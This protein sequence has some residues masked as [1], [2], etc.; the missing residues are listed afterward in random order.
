MFEEQFT[1]YPSAD[2]RN[3]D[4]IDLLSVGDVKAVISKLDGRNDETVRAAKMYNPMLHDIM[5]DP[6][7][8]GKFIEGA[9][10]K[11][12]SYVKKWKLPIAYPRYINEVALVFLYGRPVKWGCESTDTDKAFEEFQKLL[13][14]THFDSKVRQ[15]KRYAGAY[16]QS[17]MLFRVYQD[18]NGK[19]D[20]QIRVLSHE[21]NDKI[22]TR[23][24]Q[25]GN[26]LS[27]AWGYT[28]LEGETPVEHFDL[29][30][31][32]YIY[33]CQRGEK[34]W[35]INVQENK[36]KKIPVIYCQQEVEWAGVEPQIEREEYI[37]SRTADTNDYFADPQL[38]IHT[39][40][41]KNMP[42][43]DDA[44]KTWLVS[45]ENASADKMAKYLTWDSAPESK[46]KEVE[47]LQNHILSKTFTPNIDFENMKTLSNVSGKAL[48]Q[49]MVL[50]NIK[51]QK[52]QEQHDELIERSAN[53]MR[54]IIGNVL[55]V[56]LAKECERMVLTH[57]FQ[58]PFGEDIAEAIDCLVKAVDGGIQSRESAVEQSPLTKNPQAELERL[59]KEQES[60]LAA[61]RDVFYQQ[62]IVEEGRSE[63]VDT[64]EAN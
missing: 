35:D 38:I 62:S 15:M 52:H 23:F 57:E 47:Q 51:A 61:Q 46:Q 27:F 29:F 26:L 56:S 21:K 4:L 54:A 18:D 48:K 34:G 24:D 31:S 39:D 33:Y 55:N 16:T 13:R 42:E 2:E 12:K 10:G 45:G 53:L 32:N 60:N 28:I 20:C 8:Q 64:E 40:I 25:Y 43:K 30:L 17:A 36:V 6:T 44:N 59:K 14:R 41:L 11:R 50:A 19:S 37:H 49:M 7:R 63:G 9:D 5:T 3:K 58:D 1:N 22:Y